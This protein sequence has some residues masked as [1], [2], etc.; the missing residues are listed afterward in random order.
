MGNCLITQLKESVN[1]DNL[2]KMGELKF[3]FTGAGTISIAGCNGKKLKV[4]SGSGTFSGGATEVTI[5]DRE[6]YSI[7]DAC[8]LSM[9]EKYS[10][11]SIVGNCGVNV[12]LLESCTNLT[13]VNIS[14]SELVTGN[15]G[16]FKSTQLSNFRLYGCPNV[17]GDIDDLAS[18]ASLLTMD[19]KY[20]V[21]ISGNIE[22]YKNNTTILSM[23]LNNCALVKGSINTMLEGMLQAGRTTNLSF[24]APGTAVTFEHDGI[25]ES[26]NITTGGW[27]ISFT[28]S[29]TNKITITRTAGNPYIYDGTN[30]TLQS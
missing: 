7:T 8:V 6:M 30:W 9:L 2:Y 21:A 3:F 4:I 25:V 11:S 22:S 20:S 5:S 24:I 19:L 12:D 16:S 29:E 13:S 23:E 28:P 17:G 10:I 1:N 14:N 27:T 26:S 15:I 18:L